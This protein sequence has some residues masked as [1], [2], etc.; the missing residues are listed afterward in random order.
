[1]LQAMNT[2]H[3]GSMSTVHANTPRDALARIENMVLM[4][5]VGLPLR[6]IRTQIVSAIDLVVQIE[7]MRDGIRRLQAI[8][9]VIGLEG[10]VITTQDLFLY[11]YDGENRDG[12]LRGHFAASRYRPRFLERIASFGLEQRFMEI[13]GLEG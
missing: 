12:T 11:Q 2:G 10:D 4:A 5:G 9:E 6:A 13:F 1:M 3:D 8:T 7:R